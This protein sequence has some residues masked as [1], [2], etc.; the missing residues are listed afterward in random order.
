M[1]VIRIPG[2]NG[3]A[4]SEFFAENSAAAAAVCWDV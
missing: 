4:L 1:A 2:L 3:D